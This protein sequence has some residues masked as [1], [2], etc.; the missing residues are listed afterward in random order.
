MKNSIFITI[1]FSMALLYG[2]SSVKEPE[3]EHNDETEHLSVHDDATEA[4]H[5]E[6][7]A[8]LQEDH[9]DT[10]LYKVITLRKQPF[11]FVIKTGGS[12]G[13]DNQDLIIL[14]SKTAGVVRFSENSLFPGAKVV[15]G[16]SLFTISGEQLA[17]DNTDLRYRQIKADLDKASAN[18][19]RAGKL[20]ADRIIT[21]EHFLAAKNEYEKILNEY[22]ELHPS[23]SNG[24][25]IVRSADNGFIREVL[26]TEGQAVMPGDPLLSIIRKGSL[27]LKANVPPV[28]PQILESVAEASF[29]VSYSDR[30]F[31]TN[32]MG[33]QKISYGKSTEGNSF[34][35]P[36]YFRIDFDEG[37]IEGTYAEIWLKGKETDGSIV[38]PN[39]ALMEE[40]GKMYVFIRDSHGHFIKRYI[41]TGQSDG[42]NT[43]V[44]S[45]LSESESI[46]A[47]GAYTIKLAQT[48]S[49]APAHNHAH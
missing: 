40:F 34:H 29:R 18:Y 38:V 45:G 16:Q 20:I 43:L 30:L 4:I 14:S 15:K 21:E 46:V 32:E 25:N 44:T 8:E 13:S 48:T 47:S 10:S 2:C 12:I 1:V 31:R 5:D 22:N 33:G 37:L 41:T 19:E 36:V 11:A 35:V 28:D 9:P 42:E 6:T 7:T 3:H 24:G 23:Y 27:I 39:S 26:V 17:G 49:A